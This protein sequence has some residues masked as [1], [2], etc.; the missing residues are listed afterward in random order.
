M[1]VSLRHRRQVRLVA[2]GQYLLVGVDDSEETEIYERETLDQISPK[3]VPVALNA[4]ELRGQDLRADAP[5][6]GGTGDV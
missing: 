3:A 1:M 5:F 6:G 2:G 4:G